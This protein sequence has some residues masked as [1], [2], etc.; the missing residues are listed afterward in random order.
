MILGVDIGTGSLELVLYHKNGSFLGRTSSAY[1]LST[2]QS[3][4]SEQNPQDWIQAFETSLRDL[5]VDFPEMKT[6]LKSIGLSGQMHTLVLLD[7][8]NQ[9][10]RPAILWNDVRCTEEV[11]IIEDTWDIVKI[12]KNKALEG[13]TLP[14]LLWVKR[15]EKNNWEQIHRFFLPSSFLS[16]YL[17][18]QAYMDYSDASG[19]LLLDFEKN[20]WNKELF[21][22]LDLPVETA[23]QLTWATEN[24]Q[25]MKKDL[26]KELGFEEQDIHVFAGSADNAASALA[27]GIQNDHAAMLSIGTSGVFLSYESD[28]KQSYNGDLHFFHHALKDAYYSMGVTLSAGQSLSWYKEAFYP[29]STYDEL[30]KNIGEIPV[31][32]E[33]LLFTP[34]IMGERTPYTDAHIRGSFVGIDVKHSKEHFIRSILEGICFSLKDSQTLMQEKNKNFKELVSV[35]GGSLNSHWLQ[36]QADIFNVPIKTLSSKHGPSLGAVMIAAWGMGYYESIDQLVEK[37]VSYDQTYTP[38]PDHVS[39]YQKLYKIY[40]NIYEQTKDIS[41][42]LSDFR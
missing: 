15:H 21:E 32:S 38:N 37:F 24:P 33:G 22:W 12:S 16:Y 14:K 7:Q 20:Q 2:P 8:N 18:D 6:E 28:G 41:Y 23:P 36:I 10:I 26:Q 3:G 1:P 19:T 9:P 30:L 39:K 42:D 29:D 4:F 31:G 35:G 13:F 40:Q 27:A 34:Y 11:K 17:T 5:M 25:L